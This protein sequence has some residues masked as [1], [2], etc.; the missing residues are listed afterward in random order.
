MLET[1]QLF[2]CFNLLG[3]FF[4]K[5]FIPLVSL[6][7]QPASLTDV[8]NNLQRNGVFLPNGIMPID[9]DSSTSNSRQAKVEDGAPLSFILLNFLWNGL[10]L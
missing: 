6:F 4:E 7:V 8:S 5:E 3:L 2:A 1:C 10:D 9:R